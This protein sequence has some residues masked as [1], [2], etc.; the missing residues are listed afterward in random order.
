M[1][2]LLLEPTGFCL[3]SLDSQGHFQK[4]DEGGFGVGVVWGEDR[5]L[6]RKSILWGHG[7]GLERFPVRAKLFDQ[8]VSV[9]VNGVAAVHVAPIP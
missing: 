6:D 4:V 2:G 8:E 7:F 5:H 1:C 3:I 9:S